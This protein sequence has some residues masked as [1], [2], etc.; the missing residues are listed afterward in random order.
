MANNTSEL[1]RLGG[2]LDLLKQVVLE[3]GKIAMRYF[4]SDNQVWNKQGNSPVSEAD[5]E[6]DRFLKRE[7][8]RARPDYGWLSEESAD[9][10]D[11]LERDRVLIVDPIDG[12]RGFIKGKEEWCISIAVVERGRPNCAVL[13]CPAM[14]RLY[15]AKHNGGAF[16]NDRTI[17]CLLKR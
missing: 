16:V 4:R 5:I 14:D 9:D 13:Y 12:T 2:D 11:R 7:L 15:S 8:I 10:S 6:V 1:L 3:A 17:A